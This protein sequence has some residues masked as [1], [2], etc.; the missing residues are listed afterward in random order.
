MLPLPLPSFFV[1]EE[2][3][4]LIPFFVLEKPIRLELEYSL[5]SY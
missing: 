2:F 3:P 1:L 5:D 4:L